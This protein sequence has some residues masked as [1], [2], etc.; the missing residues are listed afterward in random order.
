MNWIP[1]TDQ[2]IPADVVRWTETIW[3]VQP[4]K[5]GKYRK[6]GERQVTA[7]VKDRDGEYCKLLVLTVENLALRPKSRY[8]PVAPGDELK[9]KVSTLVK[10]GCERL[11]WSDESA[12]ETLVKEQ[13]NT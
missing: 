5:N 6:L 3:S 8:K 11:L 12:R 1:A 9:K 2:F 10:G 13:E 4:G 7:E